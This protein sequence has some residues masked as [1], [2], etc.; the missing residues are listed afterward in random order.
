MFVQYADPSHITLCYAS[1][2][3]KS[4]EGNTRLARNQPAYGTGVTL[5]ETIRSGLY[6]VGTNAR[7]TLLATEAAR[8]DLHV[9]DASRAP[10]PARESQCLI[11]DPAVPILRTSKPDSRDREGR[12]DR[13]VAVQVNRLALLAL[14]AI[15]A[16]PQSGLAE[17]EAI[18]TTVLTSNYEYRGETQSANGPAAQ[19]SADVENADGWH[20][21]L[22]LS[23]VDFGNRAGLGNPRV[24]INP[25]V[26]FTA[27]VS[28]A[29]SVDGGVNYYAY[30]AD[31]GAGY[32]Y[33]EIYVSGSY[34]EVRSDLSYTGD[35]D[36]SATGGHP[37]AWYWSGETTTA[38]RRDLSAYVHVGYSWGPYW[39]R[40]GGGRRSDYAIG[41]DYTVR[42]YKW[43]VRYVGR[44]THEGDTEG[45]MI[46]TVQTQFAL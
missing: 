43:M 36:G 20:G 34:R 35:Y 8:A 4:F 45:R 18:V 12:T 38:L 23:N 26:G 30:R 9:R 28:D 7:S 39:T 25:Y 6:Y 14:C 22:F 37:A 19:L 1:H 17:T 2:F 42:R 21:G 46:L 24:E 44:H 32:D 3:N 27:R 31:G 16:D 13:G 5:Y 40:F 15:V 11:V 33:G 29:V 10:I 41:L